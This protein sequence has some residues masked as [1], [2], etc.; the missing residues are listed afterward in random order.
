LNC[1]SERII[2]PYHKTVK[3]WSSHLDICSADN[4]FFVRF[5]IIGYNPRGFAI[6]RVRKAKHPRINHGFRRM[7]RIDVEDLLTSAASVLIRGFS[8]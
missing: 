2:G 5:L 1:V 4:Q 6:L 3:I 8:A 7:R